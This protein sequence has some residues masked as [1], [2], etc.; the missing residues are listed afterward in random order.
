[1]PPLFPT[2]HLPTTTWNPLFPT[3][4][5]P[6]FF[7]TTFPPPP[8]LLKA[9]PLFS[10]TFLHRSFIFKVTRVSSFPVRVAYC[11]RLGCG[12]R[13]P[14]ART[15]LRCSRQ[16]AVSRRQS[17]VAKARRQL[18]I[19]NTQFI[20]HN[21]QFTI[22]NWP[23]SLSS[24]T[25]PRSSP[26][27]TYDIPP[28]SLLFSRVG[29]GR[30]SDSSVVPFPIPAHRTG[31]ADFPHPALRQD[32]PPDSRRSRKMHL[33]NRSTPSEP[34]ITSFARRRVPRVGT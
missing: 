11:R 16:S 17:A 18:T 34:K 23:L 28:T 9:G 29:V 12:P 31:R 6:P 3:Y 10:W 32:S 21:S 26:P 25:C 22:Q 5:L 7:S 14:P 33:A 20:I 15:P 2:Y 1:M 13:G 30:G 19:H 4:D 24:I 27:T 8:G